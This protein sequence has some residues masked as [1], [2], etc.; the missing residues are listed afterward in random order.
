MG[1]ELTTPSLARVMRP[2]DCT[3]GAWRINGFPFTVLASGRKRNRPGLRSNREG[4]WTFGCLASA[5]GAE[6]RFHRQHLDGR[7]FETR[8]KA[9][10]YLAAILDQQLREGSR[11]EAERLI[12]RFP[13]SARP[14]LRQARANSLRSQI[15]DLTGA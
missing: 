10:R 14:R 12:Q 13:E 3:S 8:T 4:S 5:N 6:H 9:L 1:L 7:K 15:E 2:G 11:A